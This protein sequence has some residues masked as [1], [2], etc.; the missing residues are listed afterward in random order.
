MA[1]SW[2]WG[3]SPHIQR[4]QGPEGRGKD[5]FLVEGAFELVHSDWKDPDKP[6]G[7]PSCCVEMILVLFVFTPSVCVC[8]EVMRHTNHL[9]AASSP[10]FSSGLEW[11]IFNSI[12]R[13]PNPKSI[14]FK[15]LSI[16]FT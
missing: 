13:K 8:L 6:A 1:T 15:F 12:K 7:L 4:K 5:S 2:Q 11:S 10:H 14:D 16:S 9:E 3:P